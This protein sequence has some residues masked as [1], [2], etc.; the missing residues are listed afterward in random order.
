[1][2]TTVGSMENMQRGGKGYGLAGHILMY[3]YL[4]KIL[5]VGEVEWWRVKLGSEGLELVKCGC[6]WISRISWIRFQGCVPRWVVC[7]VGSCLG[8]SR[9]PWGLAFWRWNC[10]NK[11]YWAQNPPNST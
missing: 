9:L 7:E 2:E 5:V 6:S 4:V 8:L 1:M 3:K 11:L 10:L